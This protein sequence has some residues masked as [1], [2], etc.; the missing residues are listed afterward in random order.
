[1]GRLICRGLS[2]YEIVYQAVLVMGTEVEHLQVFNN[3][4]NNDSVLSSS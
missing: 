1:M 2:M 3:S 4:N